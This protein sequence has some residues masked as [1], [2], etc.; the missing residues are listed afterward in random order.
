M[1]GDERE[2]CP[3]SVRSD[4]RG[5]ADTVAAAQATVVFVAR[6]ERADG[7]SIAVQDVRVTVD[8]ALVASH[9]EGSR[10]QLDP[11]MH[12]VAFEH[13]GFDRVEQRIEVREGERGREVDVVFRP[14]HVR[15]SPT[16]ETSEHASGDDSPAEGP[17]SSST[18][19]LAYALGGGA[20]VAVGLGVTMEVLGLTDR[21]HL[22][23]T[24]APTHSCNQSDVSTARNRVAVGDVA[25]GVGAVLFGGA[26]Y[27]A[28]SHSP[29]APASSSSLR[30][31]IGPTI[32]G[33]M[34]GMEGSL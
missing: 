32:G 21:T 27:V 4:C 2:E 24:C 33:L 23:Q 6:E 18:P 9:L 13:P 30:L 5:W 11:G 12:A 25:L 3:R 14:S 16:R 19:T 34:A 28:L 20:L 22:E 29:S 8:G 17:S 7:T 26:L 15:V 31:R 10:T 1:Q